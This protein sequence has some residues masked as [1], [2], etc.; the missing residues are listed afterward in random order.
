[1]AFINCADVDGTKVNWRHCRF[2]VRPY[3]EVGRSLNMKGYRNR[4][5]S[6]YTSFR[7]FPHSDSVSD[8]AGVSIM[9]SGCHICILYAY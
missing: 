5:M 7:Y 4:L 6:P 2:L 8:A 3:A 1:M 9:V